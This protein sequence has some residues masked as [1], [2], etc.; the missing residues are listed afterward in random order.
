VSFPLEVQEQTSL[1]DQLDK[2]NRLRE[3]GIISTEEFAVAKA[4]LLS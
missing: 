3:E 1:A 4:K 2:L